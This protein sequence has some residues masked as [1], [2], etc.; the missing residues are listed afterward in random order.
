MRS[1]GRLCEGGFEGRRGMV[2]QPIRKER[3]GCSH[4][5]G[6]IRREMA[7]FLGLLWLLYATVL[8]HDRADHPG[9][10]FRAIHRLD[11][12]FA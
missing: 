7:V 6:V 4:D 9:A 12:M 8:L 5:E 1:D 11:R 3:S 2:A 10:D